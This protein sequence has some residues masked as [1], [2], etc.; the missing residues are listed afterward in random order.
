MNGIKNS[1]VLNKNVFYRLIVLEVNEAI[2]QQ[3]ELHP[4]LLT[5]SNNY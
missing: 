2:F 4:I 3:D 5:L 1:Q